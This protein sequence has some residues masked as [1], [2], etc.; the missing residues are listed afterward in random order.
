MSRSS[1]DDTDMRQ[2][3]S[4][5]TTCTHFLLIRPSTSAFRRYCN[6]QHI[7]GKSVKPHVPEGQ[8]CTISSRAETSYAY[9]HQFHGRLLPFSI[10][11]VDCA[12]FTTYCRHHSAFQFI[13]HIRQQEKKKLFALLHSRPK[14]HLNVLLLEHHNKKKTVVCS[15][16]GSPLEIAFSTFRSLSLFR[17]IFTCVNAMSSSPSCHHFWLLKLSFFF[18]RANFYVAAAAAV[19][20]IVLRYN[21]L[22][23]FLLSTA[24]CGVWECM[25]VVV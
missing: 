2:M 11:L 6:F 15:F 12:V 20:V 14:R 8:R 23:A 4:L 1:I 10:V 16:V 19:G 25:R 7:F 5:A 22:N 21:F 9:I 3:L 18:P 24:V 17:I 13:L